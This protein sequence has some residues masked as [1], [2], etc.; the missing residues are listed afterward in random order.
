MRKGGEL[1]ERDPISE[2][3]EFSHSHRDES[4]RE[5][6][7]WRWRRWQ[8]TTAIRA[9]EEG[10]A[11]LCNMVRSNPMLEG[12]EFDFI[13][14]NIFGVCNVLQM[15]QTKCAKEKCHNLWEPTNKDEVWF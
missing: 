8:E 14:A 13:V 12:S 7:I 4:T 3:S 6:N 1:R 10:T 15:Y 5:H 9:R 11:E 2:S